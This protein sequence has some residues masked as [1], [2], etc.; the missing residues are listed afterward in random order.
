MTDLVGAAKSGNKRETLI[1]LRDIL[2]NTIP[3]TNLDKHVDY[4]APSD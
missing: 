2:A 3:F 4:T 1:A